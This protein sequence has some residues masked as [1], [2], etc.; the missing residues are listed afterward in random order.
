M[1]VVPYWRLIFG[2]ILAAIVIAAP[3]GL[4][5]LSA[6]ARATRATVAAAEPSRP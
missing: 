6:R 5:G 3:E 1:S 2:A 4:M